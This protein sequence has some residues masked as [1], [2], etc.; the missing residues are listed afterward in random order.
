MGIPY[1]APPT[2][3]RRWK[4]PAAVMPVRRAMRLP[5]RLHATF[6]A[7]S[8]YDENIT[9]QNEVL[10]LMYGPVLVPQTIGYRSWFGFTVVTVTGSG[11]FTPVLS[12][13]KKGQL[14]TINYR[15]GPLDFCS[16]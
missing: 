6:I 7:A 2:N 5:G 16:S 1:A 4:P 10:T 13:P 14:V 12:Q 15:L 9:H 8:F 3:D 11:D